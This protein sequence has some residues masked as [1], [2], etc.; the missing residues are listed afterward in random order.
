MP[1]L[2]HGK[3][4]EL[5][6]VYFPHKNACATFDPLFAYFVIKW[7]VVFPRRERYAGDKLSPPY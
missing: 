3:H 7:K 1:A 5:V 6:E 4:I 2:Q